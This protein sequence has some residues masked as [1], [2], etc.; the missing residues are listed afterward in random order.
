MLNGRYS[1]LERRI[2]ETFQKKLAEDAEAIPAVAISERL[3]L[4]VKYLIDDGIVT[5]EVFPGP[6]YPSALPDDPVLSDDTLKLTLTPK[7]REFIQGLPTA[8]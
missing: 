8:A 6:Y 4:L 2:I 3:S 7:G 5:P 1:D